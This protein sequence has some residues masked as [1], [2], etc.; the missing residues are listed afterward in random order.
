MSGTFVLLKIEKSPKV[1]LLSDTLIKLVERGGA[2]IV[3]LFMSM[4]EFPPKPMLFFRG[5]I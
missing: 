3:I 5:A 4:S 2:I 1:I